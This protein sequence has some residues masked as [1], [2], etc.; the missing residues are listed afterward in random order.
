MQYGVK[1][2]V[3][4]LRQPNN[5]EIYINCWYKYI[6]RYRHSESKVFNVSYLPLDNIK[7]F[8]I[9]WDSRNACNMI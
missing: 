3:N 9:Y 4:I 6:S 8:Q 2:Q 5:K 7:D 1:L